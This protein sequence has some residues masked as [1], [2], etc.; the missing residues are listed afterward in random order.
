MLSLR[1]ARPTL[2]FTALLALGAGCWACSSAGSGAAAAPTGG[3]AGRDGAGGNPGGASSGAT[4]AGGS[5]ASGGSAH[6]GA[7][8]AGTAGMAA[9]ANA[10]TS[11]EGGTAAGSG[12]GG[13]AGST[14]ALPVSTPVTDLAFPEAEGFGRHATGGRDG[15][16]YHVTSL[17]DSGPG[18]FRDAVSQPG[19]IVV[20]DVG[21]YIALETAVSVKSNITIAGQSAPGGGIGFRGGEISFANASNIICRHVRVRPGSATASTEDDALSLYRAKNVMVDHTSLEFAPWNN[22]DGVSDDWQNRPV[23]DITF[24]DSVI[25][26]PTG[27][28]FGAHTESVASQWSWYRNV[29]ANS[30]NRNPLAKVDNVFVNNVL[31]NDSA[32][33][34]THTSTAFRHDV[35]NNYFIFGPASTGTDNTWYQIDKNQSIYAAGNLKDSNLNGLLDGA[36]TSPYW[37]QG[38][39]TVLNAAWSQVAST[40]YS[41]ASAYRIAVS[42]AGALPRDALDTLVI[43]QLRTLG[44]GTIGTGAS[45]VGPGGSLYTSQS[46]TGLSNDGYGDIAGGTAPADADQD[47]MPDFWE[48]ANGFDPAQDDAM[49]KAA[50]GYARVEGYLNWLAEPHAQTSVGKSVEVDLAAYTLGWSDAAPSFSLTALGCGNVELAGDGHTARFTPP[51]GFVGLTPFE[52]VVQSADKTTYTA[53]VAVLV[54]P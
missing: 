20:F 49:I 14:C 53:R 10:G 13:V 23:T 43:S 48:R 1:L 25:A 4:N 15:K 41:A 28:Q 3:A 36:T 2:R 34:T 38:T 44:K 40:P 27:Q 42:R 30:H 26:D 22:V 16:L 7:G 24:Q 37:Y 17:N 33:Y 8:D 29:F 35:V 5:S 32:G 54:Q 31:Y 19:R 21:G 12:S 46:Q 6:A 9:G 50:D 18:S 47:G 11:G 39:G 51:A 52:F 45:S